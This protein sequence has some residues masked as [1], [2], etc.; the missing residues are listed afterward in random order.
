LYWFFDAEVGFS[1]A[2]D[3]FRQI[4]VPVL[5]SA[6]MALVIPRRH[7]LREKMRYGTTMLCVDCENVCSDHAARNSRCACGGRLQPLEN[8]R[9]ED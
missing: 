8:F 5:L 3:V 1:T 6:F 9:W 2:R 4:G 7:L